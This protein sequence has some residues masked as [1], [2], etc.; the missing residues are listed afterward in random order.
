LDD[1][2]RMRLRTR[3]AGAEMSRSGYSDDI[4]D[5]WAAICWRGAVESAL[6]GKR[7]QAFL[8]ELLAA[9]D[10]LPEHKL[11]ASELETG[12]EVCALGAVGRAR[13]IPNMHDFDPEDHDTIA[14]LFKIPHAL[15][16][17]IM[18]ENDREWAYWRNETPEQRFARMRK[19]IEGKI[20]SM[21]VPR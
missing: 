2:D 5:N 17:E 11:I 9:M 21:P 16:C 15:A 12:G 19:W 7:G 8:K 13:N 4:D 6:R 14:A 10:A 3:N 18:H 20:R 1:L